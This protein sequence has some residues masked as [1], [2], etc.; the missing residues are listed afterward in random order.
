MLSPTS[1]YENNNEEK[2][3]PICDEDVVIEVTESD[4]EVNLFVGPQNLYQWYNATD[5]YEVSTYSV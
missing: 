3:K 5:S 4:K 1:E 2:V